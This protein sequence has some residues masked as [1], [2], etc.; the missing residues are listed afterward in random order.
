[1]KIKI[2]KYILIALTMLAAFFA[3]FAVD[4]AINV[5]GS[6]TWGLPILLFSL[7]FIL[8]YLS[9][10][11]IR[12]IL[13][14][15]L[16]L[17]TVFLLNFIFALSLTHILAMVLA[18]L[19]ALWSV[20]RIKEDLRLNVRVNLWK[21]IRVGSSLML[22]AFS[23]A[24]TSQYYCEIKNKS[25]EH[26]MPHF[27]MGESTGGLTSKLLSAINP[28]FKNLDQEGLTVDQFILQTQKEQSENDVASGEIGSK[29]DQ[30]IEK[31][32]TSLSLEQKQILR[33]DALKKINDSSENLSIEQEQ[34]I[35]LE[36][37]KKF[38]EIA[39]VTLSGDEKVS[40]VLSDFIN[41]KMDQYLGSDIA[42]SQGSSPLPIIMAIGLFLTIL[43]IGSLLSTLW[44]M[45]IEAI[46]WIFRKTELITIAKFPVEMEIIEQD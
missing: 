2:L 28:D 45:I 42:D 11:L 12:R 30:Q 4:Q 6:S 39:G 18:Y 44:I 29:I 40:E 14:L 22:F 34:L 19:L 35:L 23:I 20:T 33:E 25:S 3:W 16:M 41:Q 43:P 31:S 36:G 37:R 26:L 7:L 15:Q 27:S 13:I 10:I 46:I 8:L 1:M 9:S 24:I 38:S 32:G 5:A 21:S 17:G